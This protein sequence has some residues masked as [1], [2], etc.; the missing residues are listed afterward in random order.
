MKSHPARRVAPPRPLESDLARAL[1]AADLVAATAC[2]AHEACLITPDATAVHGRER[3][4]PILAQLI[5]LRVEIDV[6]ARYTVGGAGVALL[7]E[8]W[9]ISSG[10][11]PK[12]F[13]QQT[14]PMLVMRAVEGSWKL[15]LA[16]PWGW[17]GG[18]YRPRDL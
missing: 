2:F 5:A 4:R 1:S 8:C 11:G 9:R 10:T 18:E 17:A 6:V 12:R 14:H 3:I 7:C 16:A 13:Q 15:A